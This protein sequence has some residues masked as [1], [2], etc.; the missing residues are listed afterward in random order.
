MKN[1]IKSLAF[2]ILIISSTG[3]LKATNFNSDDEIKLVIRN[4][5]SSIVTE[6]EYN[7]MTIDEKKIVDQIDASISAMEILNIRNGKYYFSSI[8]Y[9]VKND[10]FT[11][12]ITEYNELDVS[13]NLA[14]LED[15]LVT[16][17]CTACGVISGSSCA[18]KIERTTEGISNYNVNVQHLPDGCVK[19]TWKGNPEKRTTSISASAD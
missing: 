3:I 2:L 9:D 12:I 8:Q 13:A 6:V 11:T 7:K 18:K 4:N 14:I 5:H 16:H 19:L 17:T 10:K 15:G 1:L